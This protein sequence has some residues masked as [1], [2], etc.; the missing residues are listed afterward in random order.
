MR[1]SLAVLLVLGPLAAAAP[2]PGPRPLNPLNLD[3]LNSPDDEAEPHLA[4]DGLQ[5]YFSRKTEEGWQVFV[6][7]RAGAGAAGYVDPEPGGLPAGFAHPTLTPDGKT[8]YVQGPLENDRTGLF[9]A[10]RTAGGWSRPEPL[11]DL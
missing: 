5:L 4:S 1:R 3:R 6:A 11:T 10:T 9:R 8:M 2:D 7:H